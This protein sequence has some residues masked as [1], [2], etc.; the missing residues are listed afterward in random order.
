MLTFKRIS[1]E[2]AEA[3]LNI[4]SDKDVIYF[5]SKVPQRPDLTWAK[6]RLSAGTDIGLYD[7]GLLVGVFLE[8]PAVNEEIE[9]G[10]CIASEHRGKKYASRGLKLFIELIRGRGYKGNIHATHAE[11]N[12]I[13]GHMLKNAGFVENG[14]TSYFS[15]GRNGQVNGKK[16]IL[17]P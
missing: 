4:M 8:F 16:V 1:V 7:E 3:F 10:Y 9:V 5:S 13:S 11:D 17:R 2:E 15:K 6:E 14:T 12:A